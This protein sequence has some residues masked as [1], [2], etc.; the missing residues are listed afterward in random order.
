[1]QRLRNVSCVYLA[2]WWFF[3][4]KKYFKNVFNYSDE[5]ILKIKNTFKTTPHYIKKHT[6]NVLA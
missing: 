3:L 4:L 1:M 5:L 6:I 2:L